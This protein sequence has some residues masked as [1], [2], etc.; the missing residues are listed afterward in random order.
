MAIDLD[1]FD[2]TPR[3]GQAPENAKEVRRMV[4]QCDDLLD[5]ARYSF[6]FATIEGIRTTVQ[7]RGYVTVGQTQAIANIETSVRERE[8]YDGRKRSRRYE[9]WGR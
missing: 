8:N 1:K 7:E 2:D 6:A 4:E 3:P 5:D 9:G